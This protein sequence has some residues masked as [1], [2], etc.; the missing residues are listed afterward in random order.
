MMTEDQ[1]RSA[2]KRKFPRLT[3]TNI[4]DLDD[5]SYVVT[6]L[7][8]PN[9]EDDNDPFFRVNKRTAKITNYSPMEDLE[10]YSNA[11]YAQLNKNKNKGE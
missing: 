7:L 3:I 1:C 10:K 11:L 8:D 4:V 6:A 2:F 5:T 9:K